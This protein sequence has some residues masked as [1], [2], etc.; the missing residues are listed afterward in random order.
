MRRGALNRYFSK[1]SVATLEP[2]IHD[3][4]RKLCDQ[5]ESH[6]GSKKPVDL[7][8]AFSCLTT[9]VVTEYAF[10]QSYNFLGSSTFEPNLRPAIFVSLKKGPVFKQLPF[11]LTILQSLPA[12]VSGCTSSVQVYPLSMVQFCGY[13]YDA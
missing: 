9:D 13:G 1:A 3:K 2:Q 10:S 8:M 4:V 6:A 12:Y 5:L 11:L 7:T